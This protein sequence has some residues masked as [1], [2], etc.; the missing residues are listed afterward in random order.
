MKRKNFVVAIIMQ[1]MEVFKV[2]KLVIAEKPSVALALAKVLG[3]YKRQDGYMEG[4]RMDGRY[5]GI[6]PTSFITEM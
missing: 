1:K 5:G 3:A 2:S 4:N 6:T